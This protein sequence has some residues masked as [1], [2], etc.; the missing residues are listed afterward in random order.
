MTFVSLI[1]IHL[2]YKRNVPD[3]VYPLLYVDTNLH[4]KDVKNRILPIMWSNEEDV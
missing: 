1:W 3:S 4:T 2:L